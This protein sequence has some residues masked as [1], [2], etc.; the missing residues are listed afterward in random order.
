MTTITPE[1]LAS[2]RARYMRGEISHQDYYCWLAD[3]IGVTVEMLPATV[4]QIREALKTD[5]H[6]N[7]IPLI[8]WDNRDM[9][10]RPMAYTHRLPWALSDTV[11]T[12]KAVAKRA[13]LR[14]S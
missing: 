7:N 3:S 6:L 14:E 8:R 2:E 11:C 5:E 4:E 10:I 12:L 1:I 9:I 13:A